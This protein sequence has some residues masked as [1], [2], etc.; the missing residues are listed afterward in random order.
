MSDL[1]TTPKFEPAQ[2]IA[3]LGVSEILR[4]TDHANALKRA[5]R[6]VIVLGAGEPDFDTPEPILQAARRA[7]EHGMKKVD[8]FVKGP[9]SGR[10]TAIRSLQAT[11]LEVG[12]ISDVTPI[13]HHGCRSP[14]RRRV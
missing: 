11:G 1:S 7:M 10:E 5:G 9:G 2:R 6:P 3:A 4:I 12:S 14:K 13:A 8:V